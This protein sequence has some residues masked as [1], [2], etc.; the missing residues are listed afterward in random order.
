[1]NY[2]ALKAR[3]T[4]AQRSGDPLQVIDACNAA[5]RT[6]AADG[7]PDCWHRWNI[8]RQDALHACRDRAACGDAACAAALAANTHDPFTF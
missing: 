8:A 6:F 3:L 2:P 7:W 4:R 5:A 1:M